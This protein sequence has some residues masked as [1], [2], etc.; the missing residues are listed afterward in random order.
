V[1]AGHN[2]ANR[3]E[4]AD[5]KGERMKSRFLLAAVVVLVSVAVAGCGGGSKS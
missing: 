1:K 2:G 4:V 5:T 3:T